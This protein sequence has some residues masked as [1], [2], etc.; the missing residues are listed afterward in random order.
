M[1]VAVRF[2]IPG[3]LFLLTLGFGF[4]L[5]RAGKPYNGLI[6]NVHKLIAL[7][8]VVLAAIQVRNTL[9]NVEVQFVLLALIALTGLAVIALFV[10]GALMSANKP[11][12]RTLLTIHRIAPPLAVIAALL[13]LYLLEP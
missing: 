11:A 13:A 10:T 9:E 12:E 1:D 5:S 6:F 4:W 3:I 7:A 8:T 2:V